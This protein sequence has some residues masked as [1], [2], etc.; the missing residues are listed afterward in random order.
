[1]IIKP[2]LNVSTSRVECALNRVDSKDSAE[3]SVKTHGKTSYYVKEE[4]QEIEKDVTKKRVSFYP[5][6]DMLETINRSNYSTDEKVKCWYT[7]SDIAEMRKEFQ[8]T[9]NVIKFGEEQEYYREN[10]H[11]C[12]RGLEAHLVDGRALERKSLRSAARQA[13]LL[14]QASSRHVSMSVEEAIAA[15][16]MALSKQCAFEAYNVG[17]MDEVEAFSKDN[18]TTTTTNNNKTIV[19]ER[20]ERFSLSS[21]F[22]SDNFQNYLSCGSI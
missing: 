4:E 17:L 2:A 19:E 20:K 14:E 18:N 12:P 16:Y 8:R 9:I 13:V 6:L 15:R 10:E 7:A 5:H 21:I 22:A 3:M 1:M 11:F